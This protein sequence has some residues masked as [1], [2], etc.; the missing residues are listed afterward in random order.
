MAECAAGERRQALRQL[1]HRLV[2]EAGEDHMLED[3][4]LVRAAR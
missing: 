4:E 3:A 1:H 2:R